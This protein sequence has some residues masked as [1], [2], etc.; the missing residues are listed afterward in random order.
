MSITQLTQNAD[1][2]TNPNVQVPSDPRMAISAVQI[3]EL[4]TRLKELITEHNSKTQNLSDAGKI[5]ASNVLNLPSSGAMTGTQIVS[6]LTA[7]TGDAKLSYSVLKDLPELQSLSAGD[8]VTML[9][10]LSGDARLSYSLLKDTP[11]RK[12]QSFQ[13]KNRFRIK[14]TPSDVSAIDNIQLS[15]PKLKYDKKFV[16]VY[17]A[18]DGFV[19][20]YSFLQRWVNKRVVTLTSSD[21]TSGG[22]ATHDSRPRLTSEQSDKIVGITDGCGN[23]VPFHFGSAWITYNGAGGDL[24]TDGIISSEYLWNSEAQTFLDFFG[25]IYNHELGGEPDA[26]T[27]LDKNAKILFDRFGI[28]PVV[29]I[30]PNGDD[31]YVDAYQV[32][33]SLMIGTTEGSYLSNGFPDFYDIDF[34]KLLLARTDLGVVERTLDIIKGLVDTL[35][36]QATETTIPFSHWYVHRILNSSGVRGYEYPICKQYLSYINDTYGAD[37]TDTIWMPTLGEFYEYL[38]FRQNA[39]IERKVVNN[40][41]IFDITIPNQRQFRYKEISFLISGITSTDELTNIQGEQY[42]V[43]SGLVSSGLLL[44]ICYNRDLLA[45]A[46]KYTFRVENNLGSEYFEEYLQDAYF[47]VNRLSSIYQTPFIGRLS[48]FNS[49]PV[50][51][52]V[53]INSGTE[54]TANTTVTIALN[55]TGGATQYMVSEDSEFTGANWQALADNSFQYTFASNTEELKTVYVRVQ[56]QYGQSNS[57]SDTITYIGP[58]LSLDSVVID[59]GASG[60][61]DAQVSVAIGFSN[62]VPTHYRIGETADLSAAEWTVWAG[63]PVNYYLGATGN[64]TVYVQVKD[65]Y[66]ES[67]VVGDSIMYSPINLQSVSINADAASTNDQ[68]VSVAFVYTGSPSHYMVSEDSEFIGASWVAWTGASGD[69]IAFSLSSGDGTKTVYAK[70]KAAEGTESAVVNDSIDYSG[71]ATGT[72]IIISLS[73]SAYTLNTYETVSGKL[74]NKMMPVRGES[75]ANFAIKDTNGNV[76]GYYV[77]KPSLM[78]A[79]QGFTVSTGVNPILSGDTGPYPDSYINVYQG[80]ANSNIAG[81]KSLMRFSN[82][83]AGTYTIRILMSKAYVLA[84]TNYYQINTLDPHLLTVNCLNNASAFEEITDVPVSSDGYIDIYFYNVSGAYSTPGANLIEIIKTS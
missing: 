36:G 64:R 7:L 5:E 81:N 75:L 38:H 73:A 43:S 80:A 77:V 15:I 22:L 25:E 39:V 76:K 14:V 17:T 29:F 53:S 10:D 83:E 11:E 82:I 28:E 23:R 66:T 67:N 31:S 27:S 78:P 70:M 37:G 34:H 16:L 26:F 30:R 48:I 56:N 44:N 55:I 62:S 42:G 79:S 74:V 84:G 4:I 58:V 51:N 2:I 18:D 33:D 69:A 57:A 13:D 47:F 71:P 8:L 61:Q 35:A 32:I 65:A 1:R 59:A 6:A 54:N 63:S 3:N 68:S 41:V 49:A 60:T 40:S 19:G 72:K 46:E 50:L 24:H 21:P 52:S 45:L 20:I 9:S 12:I